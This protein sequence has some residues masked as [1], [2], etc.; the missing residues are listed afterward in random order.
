V[1]EEPLGLYLIADNYKN[2][3]LTNVFSGN[4]KKY[5]H[6]ALYQGSMQ[7]NPLAVGKLQYGASLAY[8]GPNAADYIEPKLNTSVYKVQELGHGV[9]EK[10]SLKSLIH[11]IKFIHKTKSIDHRK[12]EDDKD[13]V[14]DWNKKFDVSLFLKQ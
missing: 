10:D 5:K 6:G 14:H 4:H 9:H 3:F 2:P 8:L 7:E 13:L 1:N 11:F 12:K